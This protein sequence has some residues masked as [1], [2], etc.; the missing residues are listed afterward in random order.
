[1]TDSDRSNRKP[2][3]DLSQILIVTRYELLKHFRSRRLI[4]II[5]V[6]ALILSLIYLL[7]PALGYPY[8]GDRQIILEVTEI[9]PA[10]IHAQ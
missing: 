7:P 4:G 9:N 8:A 6:A 3:P 2:S 10:Q 1:M 5:I